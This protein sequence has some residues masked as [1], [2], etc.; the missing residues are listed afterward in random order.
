MKNLVNNI[1]EKLK[2]V[3]IEGIEPEKKD[4]VLKEYYRILNVRYSEYEGKFNETQYNRI[5]ELEMMQWQRLNAVSKKKILIKDDIFESIKSISN[6]A[7][8]FALK[9]EEQII[10]LGLANNNIDLLKQLLDRVNDENKEEATK[11]VSEGI[12]DLKYASGQSELYSLRT[13]DYREN[14]K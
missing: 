11:L 3:I 10:P 4:L 1:Y 6:E 2:D 13:G 7:L 14:D 8:E 12:L 9:K 5:C